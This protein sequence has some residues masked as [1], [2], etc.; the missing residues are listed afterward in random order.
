[1]PILAAEPGLLP[2][3]LFDN[4]VPSEVGERA[5]W[6]L[7]TKPRQEKSLARELHASRTNF[8]LPLI[9]RRNQVRNREVNSYLPLFAG[10]LFLFADRE[11]RIAA[12]STA[13][14]VHTLPVVDQQG[15]WRD[16]RQVHQLIHS[17]A[18]ITPEE[19]LVE[20]MT[21]EIRHGPLAGLRGKILECQ[22]RHRFVVQVD[23]IQRGASVSLDGLSLAPV[24]D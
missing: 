6:V 3:D 5:W 8:F 12:L 21:V 24:E 7:H 23:F 10:Y 11:E 18:A 17:G 22:S 13:R 16:L 20:G 4:Q 2:A 1:M 9:P 14:V 19:H 15:L